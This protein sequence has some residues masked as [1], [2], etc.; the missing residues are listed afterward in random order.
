MNIVQFGGEKMNKVVTS[1]EAILKVS[2][3]IASEKGLQ[4]IN[5]R[6]VAKECQVS[7]GS[8]YNYFPSKADLVIA[9]IEEI[10]KSFFH[11]RSDY[12]QFDNFLHCTEWVF[13]TI[14][15]GTKEYPGFFLAHA[16]GLDD[17][18]LY[19]GKDMMEK[20]FQHI[21]EGMLWV[22]HQ[23]Q[24]VKKNIFDDDLTE[25]QFIQFVFSNMLQLLSQNQESC[26]I[27][28]EVIRR[29]IY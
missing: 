10:W 11:M 14:Q 7:I 15:Q 27:L 8:I 23:D 18:S 19:Q 9:T 28:K 13:E 21:Q 25:E 4:S 17:E 29:I 3:K 22:L 2:Q 26:H 12:H 1:R 20:Y 6:A 24:Q 16:Q 5:I